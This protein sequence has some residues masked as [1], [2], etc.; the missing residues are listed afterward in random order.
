MNFLPKKTD[1]PSFE[2]DA[3]EDEEEKQE[4]FGEIF[5]EEKDFE[6]EEEAE[7]E[8]EEDMERGNWMKGI[9]RILVK[10]GFQ[11]LNVKPVEGG[12]GRQIWIPK[13]AE[14]LCLSCFKSH[15]LLSSI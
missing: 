7:E 3:E 11:F 12:R 8:E 1:K 4:A 9:R 10:E 15:K 2:K 14:L 5:F 6:E 13:S